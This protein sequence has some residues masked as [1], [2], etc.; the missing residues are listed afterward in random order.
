MKINGLA[1]RKR[2]LAATAI[3]GVLVPLLTIILVMMTDVA[4][5]AEDYQD[6]L[7]MLWVL[8]LA[9]ISYL[10]LNGYLLWKRGQTVGKR[11]L[12]IAVVSHSVENITPAPLWNLILVRA[13]FFP[14]L[15]MIIIPPYLL[16]P[17]LDLAFIFGKSRRCLHDLVCRTE[18]VRLER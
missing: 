11:L 13:W 14:A 4:E 18:V 16:L 17:V 6:N 2:R 9:I 10:L 15:Y 1:S 5:N 7:W 12:N 3:D 8:V